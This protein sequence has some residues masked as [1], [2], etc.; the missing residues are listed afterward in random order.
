MSSKKLVSGG[1]FT[2][3]MTEIISFWSCFFSFNI[4]PLQIPPPVLH[5]G[6]FC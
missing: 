5:D 6:Y 4:G 3:Q 1:D 2:F